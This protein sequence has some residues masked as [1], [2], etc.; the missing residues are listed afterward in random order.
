MGDVLS[1]TDH[2]VELAEL[3]ET[4]DKA[5]THLS[6]FKCYMYCT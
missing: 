3:R 4:F 2:E 5:I 6:E 1:I